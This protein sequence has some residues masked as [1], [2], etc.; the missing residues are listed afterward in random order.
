M[1]PTA[2]AGYSGITP[3]ASQLAS[4]EVSRA[5]LH[6]HPPHAPEES[7]I[8]LH[9][10]CRIANES[11][12]ARELIRR[13]DL[14]FQHTLEKLIL[15]NPTSEASTIIPMLAPEDEVAAAS[16]HCGMKDVQG[17]ASTQAPQ[18]LLQP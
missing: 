15:V 14:C 9:S 7:L 1:S 8:Y 18:H 3:C 10:T 5:Q 6:F 11:N 17:Y 12:V 2:T 13:L 16:L 4:Y